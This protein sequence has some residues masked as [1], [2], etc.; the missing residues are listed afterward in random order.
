MNFEDKETYEYL[1]KDYW[2]ELRQS[3]SFTISQLD[4]NEEAADGTDAEVSDTDDPSDNES[5]TESEK[6]VEET[7]AK[8]E[9]AELRSAR[10]R[11]G[12]RCKGAHV[13][14]EGPEDDMEPGKTEE[15]IMDQHKHEHD[16]H[17]SR[18]CT[19]EGWASKELKEFIEYMKED[20]SKPL[21]R[22][23]VHKLLWRYIKEHKL[24]NPRKKSEILCD[25]HLQPIFEKESV[26]QFEMFKMLNKH[27]PSKA[28]VAPIKSCKEANSSHEHVGGGD[29]LAV[30]DG[31][32]EKMRHSP[33]KF[34]RKGRKMHEEKFERPDSKEYAAISHDNISQIYLRRALLEELLDDP[35]FISKVVDTF[36]RIRV[37]GNSKTEM[38]YRLVL[39]TGNLQSS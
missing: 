30:G 24:Q 6:D 16:P 15:E 17:R 20:T 22:F 13:G 38:C 29:D 34:K 2:V 18:T 7:D 21:T 27:F 1:F 28:S 8:E 14:S 12:R 31:T 33:I 11:L 19:I 5:Y 9:N 25:G 26:G 10:R 4:K 32:D 23:A 35:E 3:L 36:V 37:P 39:V